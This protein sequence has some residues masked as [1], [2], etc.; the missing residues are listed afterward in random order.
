MFIA[1]LL[2]ALV[3]GILFT[4]V[5]AIIFHRSGP[6][7]SIAIFFILIFLLTW[8]GG[9]WIAPFGPRL[10]GVYWLPFLLVGLIFALLLSASGPSRPP[11]N[12]QEAIEEAE[13]EIAA[14]SVLNFFLWL[15]IFALVVGIIVYYYNLAS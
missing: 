3:I 12:A 15:F 8:A 1:H 9:I 7:G 4:I 11:R 5:F 2:F 10:W 6:W 13:T 14:Q